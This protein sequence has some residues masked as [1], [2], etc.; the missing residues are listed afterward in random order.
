MYCQTV[1]IAIMLL[2]TSVCTQGQTLVHRVQTSLYSNHFKIISENKTGQTSSNKQINIHAQPISFDLEPLY[3]TGIL[4]TYQL[5]L[6]FSEDIPANW[7]DTLAAKFFT[8]L[9]TGAPLGCI[10]TAPVTSAQGVSPRATAPTIQ[11]SASGSSRDTTSSWWVTLLSSS[12]FG[13]DP[14]HHPIH[15]RYN[16]QACGSHTCRK[17]FTTAQVP[18]DSSLATMRHY[19]TAPSLPFGSGSPLKPGDSSGLYRFNAPPTSSL[20]LSRGTA[21]YAIGTR[22]LE[23][24]FQTHRYHPYPDRIEKDK[25]VYNTGLSPSQV[26]DWFANKRRREKQANNWFGNKRRHEKNKQQPDSTDQ[27]I[28]MAEKPAPAKKPRLK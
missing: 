22:I 25:L 28:E 8:H 2:L 23:N 12:G 5:S 18:M 24:W 27:P 13:D 3:S 4:T 10:I 11:T 16:C 15:T 17:E 9:I 7:S 20:K 6:I 1:L 14:P 19:F 26:N 21:G